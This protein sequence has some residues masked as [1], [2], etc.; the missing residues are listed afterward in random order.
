MQGFTVFLAIA[1]VILS[2]G[3]QFSTAAPSPYP[4]HYI[5]KGGENKPLPVVLDQCQSLPDDAAAVDNTT[6]F[7]VFV[8]SEP[9]CQGDATR[10]PPGQRLDEPPTFV[11]VLVLRFT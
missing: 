2:Y 8:F 9:G 1:A 6:P 11:S 10:V 5:T 7:G 4:I 3:P